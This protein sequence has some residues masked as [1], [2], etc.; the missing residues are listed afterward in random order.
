[1]FADERELRE[2]VIDAIESRNHKNKM[3]VEQFSLV[4]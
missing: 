1:M 2:G 4:L 3:S